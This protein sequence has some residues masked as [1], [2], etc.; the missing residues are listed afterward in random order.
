MYCLGTYIG[1]T[2]LQKTDELWAKVAEAI[3]Y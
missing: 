2:A 3:A 1:F